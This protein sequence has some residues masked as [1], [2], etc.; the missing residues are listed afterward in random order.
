ME[1]LYKH[2]LSNLFEKSSEDLASIKESIALHGYDQ[3]Q[4][5]I[6]YDGRILDGFHRYSAC[7]ELGMMPPTRDFEGSYED[8]LNYVWTM[9]FSRRHLTQRAKVMSLIIRN[10]MLP[11]SGR[12]TR[13]EIAAKAGKESRLIVDQLIRLNDVAPN[14]AGEVARGERT[15]TKAIKEVLREQPG[16]SAQFQ[17]L[18]LHITSKR[19]KDLFWGAQEKML[20]TQAQAINK[21]IALFGEWAKQ[22]QDG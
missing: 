16:G 8:A 3:N 4:P 6:L 22:Q 10:D 1:D 15:A 14:V 12:L 20:M 7:R 5:V 21:A 18:T 19:S 2:E 9:N 13:T 11:K 17:D